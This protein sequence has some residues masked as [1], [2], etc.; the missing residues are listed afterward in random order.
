VER[1]PR[2]RAY[3]ARVYRKTKTSDPPGP[4]PRI[5]LLKSSHGS[6]IHGI[7]IRPR[8]PSFHPSPYGS[9]VR[10]PWSAERPWWRRVRRGPTVGGPLMIYNLRDVSPTDFSKLS[11]RGGRIPLLLQP[12]YDGVVYCIHARA[13]RTRSASAAVA[14]TGQ[15]S[16]SS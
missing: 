12:L 14:C 9:C 4:A 11:G 8:D 16:L 7:A 5:C 1:V 13:R 6:D 10:T 2:Q 15:V 3:A